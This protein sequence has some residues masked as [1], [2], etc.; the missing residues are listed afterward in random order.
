[1]SNKLLF[2]PPIF[3]IYF[4]T[5][6]KIIIYESQLLWIVGIISIRQENPK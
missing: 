3:I 6:K 2:L 1:M 4:I 5:N